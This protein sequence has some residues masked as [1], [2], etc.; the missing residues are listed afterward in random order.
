MQSFVNKKKMQALQIPNC[1]LQTIY[2]LVVQKK[3]IGRN[4]WA[5]HG[6]TSVPIAIGRR[7]RC[8]IAALGWRHKKTTPAVGLVL[9]TSK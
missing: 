9:L 4:S 5:V 8:F 7:N 1:L 2:A 3:R 6:S